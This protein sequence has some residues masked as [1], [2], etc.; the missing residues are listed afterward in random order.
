M[1]GASRITLTPKQCRTQLQNLVDALLVSGL[2]VDRL[3]PVVLWSR[4]GFCRVSWPPCA[5]TDGGQFFKDFYTVETYLGWLATRHYSAVLFDGSLL[6]M[7]LDFRNGEFAGHRLAYIPC[8]FFLGEEGAEMLRSEPILDVIEM[9][10]AR[11]EE[12]LR[13]RTPIRFDFDPSAAGA[14][15]PASHVTL[16]DQAFRIPA[17]GPLSLW[18]FIEFVFL[19]FYPAVWAEND[20]LAETAANPLPRQITAEHEQSMHLNW[21]GDSGRIA[22]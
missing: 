21:R 16:N 19:R 20:F 10:R 15:H 6:Q 4:G 8:P 9:Y 13:L 1:R 3:V 18:Q 12:C 22:G 2:A 14:D 17:C 5:E 7:T 11:G